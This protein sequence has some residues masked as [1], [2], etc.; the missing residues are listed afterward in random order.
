MRAGIFLAFA[1][2]WTSNA[3]A[4]ASREPAPQEQP[5][6]TFH[7]FFLTTPSHAAGFEM[8]GRGVPAA[9]SRDI[10][11]RAES[12][13]RGALVQAGFAV[14]DR[15]GDADGVLELTVGGMGADGEAERVF[16]ALRDARTGRLEAVFRANTRADPQTVEN[17]VTA[18]AEVIDQMVRMLPR[19]P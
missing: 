17:L 3:A 14:V 18:A 1:V 13:L 9:A 15:A 7:R 19:D 12:A 6:P 2:A 8:E 16:V 11:V 10:V 4:C 5:L